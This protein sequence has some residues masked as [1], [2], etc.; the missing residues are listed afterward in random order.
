MWKGVYPYEYTNDWEK[1][2]E[3]LP[4]KVDY[5]ITDADYADAKR[6]WNKHL[7]EY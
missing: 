4:D 2:D 1:F 6:V 3:T 5:H 7:G